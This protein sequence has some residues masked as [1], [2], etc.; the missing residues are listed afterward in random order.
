MITIP[1]RRVIELGVTLILPPL[2]MTTFC[3]SPMV[4]AVPIDPSVAIVILRRELSLIAGR[5]VLWILPVLRIWA[6]RIVL[7]SAVFYAI[8]AAVRLVDPHAAPGVGK[9]MVPK[10]QYQQQNRHW[11]LHYAPPQTVPPE[12]YSLT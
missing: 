11:Y 6:T 7:I 2:R 4:P 9:R 10:P 5:K 12:S 1:A 8:A 3:P